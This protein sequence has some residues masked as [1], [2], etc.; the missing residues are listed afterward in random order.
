MLFYLYSITLLMCYI[1]TLFILLFVNI[2]LQYI[3]NKCLVEKEEILLFEYYDKV[4]SLS[5]RYIKDIMKHFNHTDYS[6]QFPRMKLPHSFRRKNIY[7]VKRIKEH[8]LNPN[9][10][11]R[12]TII[13]NNTFSLRQFDLFIKVNYHRNIIQYANSIFSSKTRYKSITIKFMI[14]S[15]YLNF[16]L[17][18]RTYIDIH[19]TCLIY[20]IIEFQVQ[21]KNHF[22]YQRKTHNLY[23]AIRN[24]NI[25][26]FYNDNRE[27]IS[28]KLYMR[29]LYTTHSYIFILYYN[30]ITKKE[31]ESEK[32]LYIIEAYYWV[33]KSIRV[34]V[35]DPLIEQFVF[36]YIQIAISFHKVKSISLI[37][38]LLSKLN[39]L[40]RFIYSTANRIDISMSKQ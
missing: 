9:D 37:E 2:V 18:K 27:F 1:I 29:D 19:K 7:P 6:I 38:H 14:N 32:H 17:P 33:K 28:N 39:T 24:L 15:I 36:L 8:Y 12:M 26:K 25:V 34:F 20:P 3:P 31:K 11:V 30:N 21:M 16:I 40:L 22:T 10:I 4:H 23:K 13:F 5:Y 35:N